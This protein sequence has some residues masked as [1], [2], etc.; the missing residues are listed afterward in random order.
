ML[1]K[2]L[3]S[4]ID[5]NVTLSSTHQQRFSSIRSSISS[6]SWLL[7]LVTVYFMDLNHLINDDTDVVLMPGNSRKQFYHH[8]RKATQQ[9]YVDSS[10]EPLLR[11]STA[12]LCIPLKLPIPR[13]HNFTP[14]LSRRISCACSSCR[15]SKAKCTGERPQCQRCAL[16]QHDCQYPEKKSIET[17][18][19]PMDP[20]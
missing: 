9:A 18:R 7:S 12:A 13:L 17:Q 4:T 1:L 14:Y 5:H 6:C 10:D 19:Y 3:K 16:L 2:I 20:P 8:K 11:D 15:A